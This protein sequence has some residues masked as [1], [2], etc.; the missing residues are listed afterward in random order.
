MGEHVA[1][2]DFLPIVVDSRD[3]PVCIAIDV[4]DRVDACHIRAVEGLSN[5]R[6]VLPLR[7]FCRRQ[8]CFQSVFRIGGSLERQKRLMAVIGCRDASGSVWSMVKISAATK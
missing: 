3:E 5:L 8:P 7:S 2:V 1:D 6:Q 4:E